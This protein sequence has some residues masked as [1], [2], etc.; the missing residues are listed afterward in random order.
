MRGNLLDPRESYV[1]T[2]LLCWML[3][4][5]LAELWNGSSQGRTNLGRLGN[6]AVEAQLERRVYLHCTVEAGRSPEA[7]AA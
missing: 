4:T 1:D 5:S 7:A 6:G 3:W 2:G